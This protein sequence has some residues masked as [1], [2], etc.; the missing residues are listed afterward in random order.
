M[1]DEGSTGVAGRDLLITPP[2]VGAPEGLEGPGK[3]S[4]DA[5]GLLAELA[6]LNA[7]RPPPPKCVWWVGGGQA[8]F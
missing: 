4:E 7:D 5:R 2:G 8:S 6:E 1:L 3:D